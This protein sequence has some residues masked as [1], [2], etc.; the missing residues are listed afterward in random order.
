MTKTGCPSTGMRPASV[1][2]ART[3]SDPP[4]NLM[5]ATLEAGGQARVGEGL[6]LPLSPAQLRAAGSEREVL[7]GLRAHSLRL[8]PQQGDMPL[9]AV[10]DLAEISGSETYIHVH[11]GALSIVAQLPGVHP[12]ELGARCVLYCQPEELL[13]FAR[14]GRLLHAPAGS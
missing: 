9:D 7:L 5:P 12:Q 11:R 13:L 10:V 2:V 8:A 1:Q 6:A 3:F 4:V 14:D